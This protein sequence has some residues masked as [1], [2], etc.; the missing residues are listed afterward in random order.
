MSSPPVAPAA[1]SSSPPAVVG[2]A[3]GAG[4][5]RGVV[6][7]MLAGA[8]WSLGG[9]LV[10]LVE[11]AGEWQIL[12]YRSATLVVVLLAVLA[13]RY[14]GGIAGA[15]RRAGLASLVGAAGIATAF[16]SFI[17]ALTHASVAT[18]VLLLSTAPFLSAVLAR[19]VLGE[20]VR[21]GTWIAMIA[22]LAGVALMVARGHAIGSLGGAL[23]ALLA[24]FGFSVFT[25]AQRFGRANDMTPTVCLAGVLGVLLA[26]A[27]LAFGEGTGSFAVSGRDLLVCAAM[28]V[29]QVGLGLVLYTVGARHV[30]AA[31]LALLSLTEVVL[32]PLWV[33]LALGEV[34]DAGMLAG[35]GIVFAAVVGQALGSLRRRPPPA[36]VD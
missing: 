33:W 11:H 30:P 12:L 14:R 25:V 2:P 16:A 7:V 28:G 22:A 5:A 24:A 36:L 31:Q 17:F 23:A 26:G 15:F 6:L 13:A 10:R 9:I 18:A 34:P 19:V 35:G 21:R 8:C 4:Y 32:A 3:D 1:A 27:L 29:L 20:R